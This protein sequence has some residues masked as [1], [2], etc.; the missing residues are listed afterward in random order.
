[1]DAWDP[2]LDL[3]TDQK[4]VSLLPW[5]ISGS[6][7]ILIILGRINYVCYSHRHDQTLLGQSLGIV[8]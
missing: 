1:M 6:F 5:W 3:G 4:D 7:I 2:S 8:V